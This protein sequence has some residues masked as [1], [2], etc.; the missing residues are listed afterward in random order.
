METS[1]EHLPV[2]LVVQGHAVYAGQG[3]DQLETKVRN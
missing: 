3:R 1:G 2:F